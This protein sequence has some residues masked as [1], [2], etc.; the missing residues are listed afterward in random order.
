MKKVYRGPMAWLKRLNYR[1][2]EGRRMRREALEAQLEN[3]ATILESLSRLLELGLAEGPGVVTR[4]LGML[5]E[6][7][8]H[9]ERQL[10]GL[11]EQ[12]AGQAQQTSG[13]EEQL[14]SQAQQ[15]S[16]LEAQLAGQARQLSGLEEQLADQAQQVSGLLA[17]S[18]DSFP[19][20]A[21]ARPALLEPELEVLARLAP[22][23][24]PRVAIDVGAH[25]GKFTRVLLEAGFTV[26]A[27]EPNPEARAE[28]DRRLGACAGLTI[29]AA[30]GGAEDGTADLRLVADA[31]G[32]FPDPTLFASLAGLPLPDGLSPAGTVQVPLRRLDTLVR[33]AGLASPSVVKI[34]A[35]GTD[36]DVL[37]G[38]GELR[39][40]LMQA[41]FWDEALPLSGPGARNQ[42]PDL[43][44]HARAHG[45]PFH[46]VIFR[47]WG[48]ERPAFF[49][50]WTESPERSWG[51]VFFFADRSL[52]ERAREV[53]A[54]L[55]PEARFMPLPVKAPVALGR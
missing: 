53:V 13:L 42:L 32:F 19:A 31:N 8:G 36:L 24:A 33:E 35:E 5:D 2:V 25:H 39:P 38:L 55:L 20:V 15:T 27:M 3:D 14:A 16:G 17:Q 43:V 29:H 28:L 45:A 40:A 47:R 34:D 26:H 12:L 1:R 4:R 48:D 21:T 7:F 23:L 41:E 10:T 6:R 51:D 49:T 11:E 30:A 52:Y 18:A 9:L 46:L 22:W 44:T 54:G 37:R 50:G